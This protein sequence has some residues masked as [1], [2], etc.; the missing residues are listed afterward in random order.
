M[1]PE[2]ILDF[3]SGA[4]LLLPL[5]SW[6]AVGGGADTGVFLSPLHKE[7]PHVI[8]FLLPLPFQCFVS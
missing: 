1:S 3:M 7:E 4:V 8:L 5:K 2:H 6:A